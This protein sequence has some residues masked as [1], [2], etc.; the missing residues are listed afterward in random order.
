MLK[1]CRILA[2]TE[3]TDDD[4]E[5]ETDIADRLNEEEL[6]RRME[7]GQNTC[8][9]GEEESMEVQ[10]L[11]Q[12]VRCAAHT[13][14]LAILDALDEPGITIISKTRVVC[15]VLRSQ[16]FMAAIRLAGQKKP[17]IDV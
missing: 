6:I 15:K 9:E 1:A 16:T 12:G 5:E 2:Q 17:I 14:Q 10:T 3:S 4:E 11:L 8:E 13:L 7:E